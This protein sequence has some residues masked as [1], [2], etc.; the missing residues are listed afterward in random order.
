VANPFFGLPQFVGTA[1]G[2]GA[3]TTVQQLL[4][5]FPQFTSFNRGQVDAGRSAYHGLQMKL[6]KRLSETLTLIVSHTWSKQLDYISY[7]NPI[8]YQVD[9]SLNAE[10]RTHY[11]SAGWSWDLPFGR[12]RRWLDNASRAASGLFGGWQLGGL[13][14]LQSGRPVFFNTNL[15]WNGQEASVA[16]DQRSLDRWFRTDPFGIIAKENTYALRTTPLALAS[17]RASR[18][19]NIDMAV[20]KNFH[21]V[22][23]VTLQFRFEAF[24]AFNRPRF[25]DPNINPANAAF[26]TVAKSQLNQPRMLQLALKAN[27]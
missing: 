7:L 15:T 20:F 25:G 1:L 24:N 4:S 17:I 11:F 27:F 14:S 6:E 18:Q 5:S 13:Y 8:A 3:T 21:P 23:R 10:D 26:G 16:R 19:N 12:G 2:T 22:E 9:H